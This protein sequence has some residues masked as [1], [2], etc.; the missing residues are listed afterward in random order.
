MTKTQYALIKIE[1][2]GDRTISPII[3][4]DCKT[5]LPIMDRLQYPTSTTKWKINKEIENLKML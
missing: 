5:P 1:K 2:I 3:G 4:G